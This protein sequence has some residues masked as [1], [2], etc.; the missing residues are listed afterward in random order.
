MQTGGRRRGFKSWFVEPYRQVK[1]GLLFL[2]L[3]LL[4]SALILSVF[5]YYIWDVYQA[6]ATY[7]QLSGDQ[8][9][10]ILEK[11]QTP[12][13]AGIVLI[14]V[15]MVSTI[16]ISVRYTHAIYGPLVSIHR[17]LDDTLEGRVARPLQL[18]ESDQL[19]ELAVKLNQVGERL[20][21]HRRSGVLQPVYKFLD[22]LLA[23]R[24]P[25]PLHI[26][27]SDQLSELASKLNRLRDQYKGSN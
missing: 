22:E 25:E 23:G 2:V 11:M 21:D 12:L 10:Q 14:A 3:N 7:F 24:R 27:E 17:F 16:L 18:R 15:F 4:F 6:V 26:R 13:I 8:G 9:G 20:S 5:G 1:L 19:K